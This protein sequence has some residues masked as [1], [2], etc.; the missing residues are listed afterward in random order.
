MDFGLRVLL[1]LIEPG[2]GFITDLY[3]V[4]GDGKEK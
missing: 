4:P 1:N 3:G 2:I